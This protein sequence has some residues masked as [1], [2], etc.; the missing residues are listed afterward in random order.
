LSAN[1]ASDALKKIG[2][3]LRFLVLGAVLVVVLGEGLGIK[4]TVLLEV[5]AKAFKA[6]LCVLIKK[7]YV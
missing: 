7:R 1:K 4:Y 3:S 5:K 6:R 2:L